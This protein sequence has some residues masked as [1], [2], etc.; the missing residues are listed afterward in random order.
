MTLP[1]LPA[2]RHRQIAAVFT[3]RVRGT[4]SW[5]APSP[6]AGWAARDVVGHL[7]DWCHDF[8]AEGAGLDLPRGPSADR[9]PV[10]AWTV[11]CDGV[12]AVLDDPRTAT[13]EF[14][15]EHIGRLPLATAIDQFYVTD[16]FLHTWDLARASGQDDRLDPE[17]CALLL[18]GMEQMEEVLRSS[19]QYGPRVDVPAGADAQTGLLGFIGRDPFWS[20]R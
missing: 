5:D 1:E 8:L 12:Q 3:D 13:R 20:P 15:H 10:L 19:G 4:R 7:T 16:V 14:T 6:V 17:F 18:A 9:D 11:H 2:D